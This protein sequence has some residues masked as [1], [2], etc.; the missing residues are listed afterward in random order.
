M[1]TSKTKRRLRS[2]E[3]ESLEGK[4]LLSTGIANPA[5]MVH[6][7]TASRRISLNGSLF[8][9]PIPA[10]T[11]N[12]IVVTRFSIKGTIGS[13]GKVK[14]TVQLANAI[15]YGG[16]PD[17]S[18][19]TLTLSNRK[20]S[21]ELMLGPSST[22]FYDY[23]VIGGTKHYASASGSGVASLHFSQR[24]FGLVVVVLHSNHR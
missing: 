22:N 24:W 4:V 21:V 5:S 12:G 15:R 6:L 3:F 7:A 18:N 14:G 9:I 13:M 23:I 8:G 20:G 16:E 1:P 2:L 19:A 17:M 10:G 11:T